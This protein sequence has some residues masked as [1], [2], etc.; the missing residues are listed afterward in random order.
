[1]RIMSELSSGFFTGFEG[2]IAA[3]RGEVS[4]DQSP[5]KDRGCFISEESAEFHTIHPKA[6]AGTFAGR[7]LGGNRWQLSLQAAHPRHNPE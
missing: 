4:D 2:R 1:M 5:P 3:A 7:A 6:A